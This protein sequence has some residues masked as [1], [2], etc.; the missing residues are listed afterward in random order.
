M[1]MNRKP[2]TKNNPFVN[3]RLEN[4]YYAMTYRCH[5]PNCAIYYKYGA[6][7]IKVCDEWRDD[8]FKFYD[9]AMSHGYKENLSIDRI[10]NSKGYSPDNCRWATNK[11]QSNNRTSNHLVE[12]NGEIHSIA[13]WADLVGIK[14]ETIYKRLKSGWTNERA[15]FTP[16]DFKKRNHK[17]KA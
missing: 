14:Q 10:D 12:I 6:K 7:G 11:Q 2:P 13:E 15:V 4:I 3:S 5:N 16:I 17:V 9:W 8:K 1:S